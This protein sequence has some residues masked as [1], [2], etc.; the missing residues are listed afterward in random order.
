MTA[1][2]M[3]MKESMLLSESNQT[4]QKRRLIELVELA[5][6]R[7]PVFDMLSNPTPVQVN[8]EKKQ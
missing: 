1:S 7:S 6:K 5:Q 8:M 3:G 4:P 2:E